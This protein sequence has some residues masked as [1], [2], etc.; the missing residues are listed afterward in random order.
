MD[1]FGI[2]ALVLAAVGIAGGFIP[3][4]PG[5][6][7]SWAALLLLVFSENVKRPVTSTELIIWL[8]VA[9]V[10]TVLDYIL[11]SVMTRLT[12][13]H[14]EAARGAM[15]GLVIG[16]FL[17]PVGMI[18]GSFLG[19]FIGELMVPGQE[20]GPALKAAVGTFLAFLLTTG[21]K[22]IISAILLWKVISHLFFA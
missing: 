17:T 18:L 7:L 13:G 16:L 12:G 6:P 22:V 21:L 11:P 15:V 4:L 20:A 14:K 2:L 8:A 19:A 9:V 10:I 3:V 5:P 1:I